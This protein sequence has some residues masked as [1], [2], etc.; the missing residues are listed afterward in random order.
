[1]S[2]TASRF[3]VAASVDAPRGTFFCR[4]LRD[5][6]LVC[7]IVS[8]NMVPMVFLLEQAIKQLYKYPRTSFRIAPSSQ[9]HTISLRFGSVTDSFH[10]Q[11]QHGRSPNCERRICCARDWIQT[12]R[13]S[14]RLGKS[15]WPPHFVGFFV[16]ARKILGICVK[17]RPSLA[18]QQQFRMAPCRG[19]ECQINRSSQDLGNTSMPMDW[20]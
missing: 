14:L 11:H 9:Q 2:A 6:L 5:L 4:T 10:T 3:S 7:C 12:G 19:A 8:F 17:C 1:M 20:A 13:R 16:C 15:H 18:N